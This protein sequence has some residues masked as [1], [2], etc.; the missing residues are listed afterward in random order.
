[1]MTSTT[2]SGTQQLPRFGVRVSA[3]QRTQ[4]G[5]FLQPCASGRAPQPVRRGVPVIKNKTFFFFDMQFTVEDGRPLSFT[6][7]DGSYCSIPERR[8]LASPRRCPAYFDA[9]GRRGAGQPDFLSGFGEC[10][11]GTGLFAMRSWK[12]HPDGAGALPVVLK[13]RRSPHPRRRW[14]PLCAIL[15]LSAHTRSI[16]TSTTSETPPQFL[17]E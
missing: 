14:I 11:C 12:Y 10:S 3:Q 13:G 5:E 9:M 8:F 1:M 16:S 2:K 4:C 6:N 15:A 7:S 17:I